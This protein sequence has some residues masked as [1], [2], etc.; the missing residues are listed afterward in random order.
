MMDIEEKQKLEVLR[1]ETLERDLHLKYT[2]I[3]EQ[4]G[5]SLILFSFST[6]FIVT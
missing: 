4:V 3:S 1:I 6:N 2:T 5:S